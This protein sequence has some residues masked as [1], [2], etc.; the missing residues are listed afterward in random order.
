MQSRGLE[1]LVGFFVCL[2]IAAVFVL[3]MRVS[4][5]SD[6]SGIE[7][8]A[9][10]AAFYNVGGL[11]V[12]APVN[13]AG[14]RIGRVSDISING[15]TFQAVVTMKI[16]DQY[17]LPRDSDASILTAGLL[18]SQYIGIGPGGAMESLSDGDEIKFTQSAIVLEQIIGQVLYS[19]TSGGGDDAAKPAADPPSGSP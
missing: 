17:E 4:N 16:E 1:I 3:T 14:V 2:G 11:K 5:L 10:T 6:V 9:V 15:Q 12:G 18:G 19:L 13:L 7:G 8:Y